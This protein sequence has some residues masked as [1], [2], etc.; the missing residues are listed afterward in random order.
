M[1]TRMNLSGRAIDREAE[2]LKAPRCPKCGRFIKR[3]LLMHCPHCEVL[4]AHVENISDVNKIAEILIAKRRLAQALRKEDPGLLSTS[5]VFMV[6]D[7][8][9]AGSE[10]GE[11][12]S[13]QEVVE[14]VREMTGKGVKIKDA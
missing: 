4:V 10:G 1:T 8:F 3:E 11:V 14:K 12:L 9:L 7:F 5:G 6:Q 2:A 13:V